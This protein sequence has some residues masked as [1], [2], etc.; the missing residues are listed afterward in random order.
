M[1]DCCTV[2]PDRGAPRA[3]G[4]PLQVRDGGLDGRDGKRREP[5]VREEGVLDYRNVFF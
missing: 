1:G 2:S 3:R 4:L 5:V